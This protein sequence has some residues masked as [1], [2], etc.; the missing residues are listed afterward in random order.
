MTRQ[1]RDT[2]WRIEWQKLG[3]GWVFAMSFDLPQDSTAEE[4][5]AKA[6]QRIPF[7]AT[8]PLRAVQRR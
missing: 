6:Q 7:Y 4:A 5:L 2:H 1:P 8:K 3:V